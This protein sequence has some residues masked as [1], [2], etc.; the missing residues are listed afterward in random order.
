MSELPEVRFVVPLPG[1]ESLTRF[2][3]VR[4]DDSGL[5]YSLTS[6]EDPAVRLIVMSPDVCFPDYAPE[7][8]ES[9][10]AELGIQVAEDA[11]TLVVVNAAETFSASTANLLAPIVVHARTGLAAQLLLVGTDHPLRAPLVP[12]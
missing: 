5:L 6:L 7:L 9:S 3:L 12:A 8:D 4:L 2:A 10:A 11:V 1:L